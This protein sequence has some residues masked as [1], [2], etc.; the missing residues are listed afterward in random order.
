MRSFF[1]SLALVTLTCTTFLACGGNGGENGSGGNAGS[2][3]SGNGGSAGSGGDGGNGGGGGSGEAPFICDAPIPHADISSPTAVVGTGTPESCTEAALDAALAGGGVIVFDCGPDPVTI[4]LSSAKQ[5]FDDTVIDGGNVVT[6][7]GGKKNRIFEMDTKNFEATSPTLTV[8]RLL[9]RDGKASGTAIPLGTDIDG[10]GGA[11]Y[12]VGGNVN[13]IDTRFLDNEAALEGPDVAGGAIYSIGRGTLTVSLGH[14]SN[15][16]AANGG[17]IGALG[18]SIVIVN[19]TLWGNTATGYGANYI[20]ANGQQAGRGGN[21]GAIS[22]DGQGRTLSLCGVVVQNNQGRAFGGALFRTGYETEPTTID[23]STFEGNSIEDHEGAE[24]MS[25]SAGGLYIQGTH[26]TMTASTI[27]NNQSEA[28]AGLWILGHGATPA[29]ADLTNVTITGN[30]TYPRADFTTRG[31]GGGLIIGDNTTGKVTNCTIA[32]NAAQFA[33]GIS[34]VTQL[35]V[36]NTIVSN[37]ADNEYTPLNCTGNAYAQPPGTGQNNLQW[38][39]GKKD[40]MDCTPGITRADPLL[41]DLEGNGGPT[42]TIAPQTGSP[43]I[44]AGAGCPTT[45]QRGKPRNPAKCTL[46]A[47]EP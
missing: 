39:N 46:G 36:L 35:E 44:G 43:A 31:I 17:A 34:N 3:G 27:A 37:D 29:I 12:H 13:V 25:S 21:G 4:T 47:Y 33:S 28:F 41:G 8:Q 14:F 1:S 38:P 30:T 42:R 7:S 45:D 18:A 22:M 10:G 6:L 32:G 11:I 23:R 20:D 2:A 16:R 15:N 9:L 24:G 26:V 40:D 5:I 19:S